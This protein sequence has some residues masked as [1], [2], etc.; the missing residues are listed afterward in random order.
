MINK[1]LFGIFAGIFFVLMLTGLGS[2]TVKFEDVSGNIQTIESGEQIKISFNVT[3]SGHMGQFDNATLIL[4]DLFGTGTAIWTGDIGEFQLLPN[5]KSFKELTLNVPPSQASGVYNGLINFAG[6]YNI[7]G[8]SIEVTP[9]DISIT[10]EN[11]EPFCLNGN[12]G[13]NNISIERIKVDSSGDDEEW[14]LLEDV[15]IDID[16]DNIGTEDL[17]NVVVV[18][19][20]FDSQGNDF[21]G[22]LD[23]SDSDEEEKE[24]GDIDEGEED[25]VVFEFRIPADF[26]EGN[27][28][29]VAKAYPDG[30]ENTNCV[31]EEHSENIS[32]DRESDE[33]KSVVIDDLLVQTE[34]VCSEAVSGTATIYNIGTDDYPDQILV[35]MFNRDLGIDEEYLFRGD[36]DQGD[37]K[38]FDFNF[39]VPA[40]AKDGSYTI[41]FET[42]YDYDEDDE[43]Y[44]LSSDTTFKAFV[45]VF[46]CSTTPINSGNL[47]DVVVTANQESEA[48]AGEEFTVKLDLANLGS[49]S[50]N[51]V[52]SVSDFE[53]W[54]DSG[55]ASNRIFTINS[56]NSANSIV[57]FKVKP[58]VSGKQT[59]TLEVMEGSIVKLQEFEVNIQETPSG[60]NF[61]FSNQ[62]L[63]WVIGAVNLILIILIIFVAIRLTRR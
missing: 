33:D 19:G 43:T 2:A 37:D 22:D 3:A 13:V 60:F 31:E 41:E 52:I 35:K 36:L 39:I 16:V 1:K 20:L 6:V 11:P 50:K 44:G 15:T 56:G 7:S 26:D 62:G 57:T 12:T 32:L 48:K 46:G 42:Y 59:F 55:V 63:L 29:L 18:L 10:V 40:T 53:S 54:A 8:Q 21:I 25:T 5:T 9:L 24:I 34:A 49:Q 45:R 4:P 58:E 30:D 17:D 14:N 51:L 27:Y 61:D 47:P 38:D 28:R 23:F